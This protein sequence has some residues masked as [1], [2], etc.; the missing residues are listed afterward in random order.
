MMPRTHII[1]VCL[2]AFAAASIVSAG[3]EHFDIDHATNQFELAMQ[4]R[5]TLS[6][7]HYVEGFKELKK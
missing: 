4:D 3:E 7:E 5:E 1:C 2:L 6:L